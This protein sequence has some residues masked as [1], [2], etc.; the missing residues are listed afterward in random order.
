MSMRLTF[1]DRMWRAANAAALARLPTNTKTCGEVAGAAVDAIL[2]IA[3]QHPLE[4][5]REPELRAAE[6]EAEVNARAVALRLRQTEAC[7]TLG[8]YLMSSDEEA[9]V[10]FSHLKLGERV[11]SPPLD[12]NNLRIALKA[13]QRFAT[14]EG[15]DLPSASLV[16]EA[17]AKEIIRTE[18]ALLPATLLLIRREAREAAA[19]ALDLAEAETLHAKQL[20]ETVA[21]RE[22]TER[23]TA[24]RRSEQSTLAFLEGAM[25]S[26]SAAKEAEERSFAERKAAQ[27]AALTKAR[28][29][30]EA[31]LKAARDEQELALKAAR[32]AQEA[33]LKAARDEQVS[34][35]A[36]LRASI[37]AE[38]ARQLEQMK[39]EA[40]R[41]QALIAA[42]I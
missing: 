37:Q 34:A 11:A 31:A 39:A 16:A 35:L 32:D 21:L 22:E 10:V 27:E 14:S 15:L 26:L 7:S 40:A 13:L 29:E 3:E 23:L 18:S 1:H 8:R 42:K 2:A 9:L 30:Q 38:E 28:E 19:R 33:T 25:A 4:L 17:K 6:Q 36:A 41:L 20:A 24:L 12:A 5:K